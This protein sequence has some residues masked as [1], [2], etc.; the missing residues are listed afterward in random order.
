[1]AIS[2]PEQFQH[3]PAQTRRKCKNKSEPHIT[4]SFSTTSFNKI[5]MGILTADQSPAR[6]S[7]FCTVLRCGTCREEKQKVE[8]NEG[9]HTLPHRCKNPQPHLQAWPASSLKPPG[10]WA[11]VAS[12]KHDRWTSFLRVTRRSINLARLTVSLASQ[13]HHLKRNYFDL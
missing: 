9:K 12:S 8:F 7:C 1:M 4:N 6:L 2:E 3:G 10:C 5:L 13:S 11:A